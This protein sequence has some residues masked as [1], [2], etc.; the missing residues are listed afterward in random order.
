M[1]QLR[2]SSS[3]S[4]GNNKETSLQR[5]LKGMKEVGSVLS[6]TN[7]SKTG[8]VNQSA[9]MGLASAFG[10]GGAYIAA[11]RIN[12]K[13]KQLLKGIKTILHSGD[14]E[15]AE[16]VKEENVFEKDTPKQPGFVGITGLVKYGF[17]NVIK[18]IKKNNKKEEK[19]KKSFFEKLLKGLKSVFSSKWFW[20][21]TG[22]AA[23]GIGIWS[24]VSNLTKKASDAFNLDE[25]AKN[26]SPI[27]DPDFLASAREDQYWGEFKQTLENIEASAPEAKRRLN[28]HLD[29]LDYWVDTEGK[30]HYVVNNGNMSYASQPNPSISLPIFSTVPIGQGA[31]LNS[32]LLAGHYKISSRFGYRDI[33][34]QNRNASHFHKGVDLAAFTG[35]P[36][37]APAGGVVEKTVWDEK[38]GNVLVVRHGMYRTRYAH[39]SQFNVAPGQVLKGGEMIARVGNTGSATTG[40]HLHYGIE[41]LTG[42]NKK[43]EENWTFVD[44]E[45]FMRNATYLT[46]GSNIPLPQNMMTIGDS[47][48]L[49]SSYGNLASSFNE[50][51]KAI[52]DLLND[53][54]RLNLF[55]ESIKSGH[56]ALPKKFEYNKN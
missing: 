6:E 7:Y 27:T 24:L 29:E 4:S 14:S 19:E 36:V 2:S 8:T 56:P 49:S 41:V 47:S 28:K 15:D 3:S 10:L 50:L 32:P 22:I 37:F 5:L 46:P 34:A 12:Q 54:S 25:I 13:T 16:D 11:S 30:R 21:T 55:K 42:T 51:D 38:A 39:L 31:P 20:I 1:P 48:M 17:R 40:S 9:R 52:V 43:G 53:E 18:A 23:L 33:S 26:S 44:P 35:T 45:Q